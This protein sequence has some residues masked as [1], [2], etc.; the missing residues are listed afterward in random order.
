M[1]TFLLSILGLF[2]SSSG[3][4]KAA[5]YNTM[6]YYDKQLKNAQLKTNLVKSLELI[7]PA[8]AVVLVYLFY[9]KIYKKAL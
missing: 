6:L 3:K 4:D 7:I 9:I 1:P 8:F 2:T 5:Y